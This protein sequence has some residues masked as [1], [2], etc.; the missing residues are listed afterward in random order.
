MRDD[1]KKYPLN[2]AEDE[3]D[4]K[5]FCPNCGAPVG[6]AARFC[7]TCGANLSV[8]T[9]INDVYAGPEFFERDPD[10]QKKTEQNITFLY[11]GPRMMEGVYASPEPAMKAVYAAPKPKKLL[12]NIKDKLTK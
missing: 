9:E 5:R 2:Y 8:V 12:K 7:M 3:N 4:S 6:E 10:Q 1:I 11:G